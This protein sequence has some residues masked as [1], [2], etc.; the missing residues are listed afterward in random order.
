MQGLTYLH[1]EIMQFL[2]LFK[3]GKYFK[4]HD[5]SKVP[6]LSHCTNERHVKH[7][8]TPA[9]WVSFLVIISTAEKPGA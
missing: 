6:E 2:Y 5:L 9:L 7:N 4:N 3:H 1:M 8:Q